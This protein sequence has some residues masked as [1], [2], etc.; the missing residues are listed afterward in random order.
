MRI[1]KFLLIVPVLFGIL[2]VSNTSVFAEELPEYVGDKIVG[3]VYYRNDPTGFPLRL[4]NEGRNG[5][6]E[7][8]KPVDIA[9]FSYSIS[10]MK[11]SF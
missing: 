4:V 1:K 5:R 6:L 2:F 11:S 8:S 10:N 9:G 3:K 7:F